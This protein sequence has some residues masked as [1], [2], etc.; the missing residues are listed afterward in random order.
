MAKLGCAFKVAWTEASGRSAKDGTEVEQKHNIPERTRL[1]G[2]VRRSAQRKELHTALGLPTASVRFAWDGW[3]VLQQLRPS[4]RRFRLSSYKGVSSRWRRKSSN[5]TSGHVRRVA[6]ILSRSRSAK[7]Y[8]RKN[9]RGWNETGRHAFC[10]GSTRRREDCGRDLHRLRYPS[11]AGYRVVTDVKMQ[12]R[13][14]LHKISAA[15]VLKR[16]QDP[17]H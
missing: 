11:Y 14:G 13:V 4:V 5:R 9:A 1:D 12:A 7:N 6:T 10:S 16:S 3:S 2:G 17:A 8:E 15:A